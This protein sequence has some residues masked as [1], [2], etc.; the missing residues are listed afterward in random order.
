MFIA[1]DATIPKSIISVQEQQLL[2]QQ[3][4]EGVLLS[5][6]QYPELSIRSPEEAY[7]KYC[8]E[9][10]KEY[11]SLSSIHHVLVKKQTK[12]IKKYNA[13][14]EIKFLC[15]D[16]NQFTVT[17]DPLCPSCLEFSRGNR[18]SL[19]CSQCLKT[20]FSPKTIAELL[21]IPD[22][23]EHY[24]QRNSAKPALFD[25]IEQKGIL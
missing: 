22:F 8:Q 9:Y 12:A 2:Q 19:L 14:R 23:S 11:I 5:K 7:K 13:E 21:T 15:P 6:I 10:G 3:R 16:C 18:T 20:T 24:Q 25:F 17:A 1:N 4:Q